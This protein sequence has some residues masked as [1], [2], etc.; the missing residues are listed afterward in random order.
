M[1]SLTGDVGA[2]SSTP[3]SN[4]L[5]AH[6]APADSVAI[7]LLVVLRGPCRDGA[8]RERIKAG[9]PGRQRREGRSVKV[10]AVKIRTLEVGGV[11]VGP[12]SSASRRSAS[13]RSAACKQLSRNQASRRSAPRKSAPGRQVAERAA[14]RRSA[15]L[16]CS[17]P[18]AGAPSVGTPGYLLERSSTPIRASLRRGGTVPAL[19]VPGKRVGSPMPRW[20]VDA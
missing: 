11:Q 18:P 2:N 6:A 14:R 20:G 19:D 10:G 7:G 4:E 15:P 16:R 17:R 9:R 5:P 8:G 3:P 13:R 12:S 1:A